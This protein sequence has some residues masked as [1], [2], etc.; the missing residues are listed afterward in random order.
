[1]LSSGKS[2]AFINDTPV[3]LEVLNT[4]ALQLIDIHSQNETLNLTDLNYL[5]S[6]IDAIAD[7]TIRIK[8]Y[9]SNYL[10]YRQLH[11]QLD[12]FR[13]RELTARKDQD[14]QAFLLKELEEVNLSAD[15]Y[16]ELE[17][18]QKQLGNLELIQESLLATLGHLDNEN[19][20]ILEQLK[21]V[22]KYL[23]QISS[24]IQIIN[25]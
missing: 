2:R 7:N 12:D 3:K 14:Y 5:Y 17:Q 6:V 19:L 9:K 16:Q 10:K 20:G 11:T 4:V 18:L 1:M 13:E 24:F 21:S 15:H 22:K 25:L 23:S 8:N